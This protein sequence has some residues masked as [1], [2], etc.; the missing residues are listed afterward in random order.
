MRNILQAA[1]KKDISGY[2]AST[3]RV[4][5]A[6]KKL[7]KH[8]KEKLQEQVDAPR[9]SAK[10]VS[11]YT[12]L[13]D[14]ACFDS[15]CDDLCTTPPEIGR[16]RRHPNLYLTNFT[17]KR[18]NKEPQPTASECT[19][20]FA[21]ALHMPLGWNRVATE[22]NALTILSGSNPELAMQLFPKVESPLPIGGRGCPEDVRAYAAI[23][24]FENYWNAVGIKGLNNI[25]NMSRHIGD[26]GEYPYRAMSSVMSKLIDLPSDD[27]RVLASEILNEAIRYYQRGSQFLNRDEEFFAL[28][29]RVRDFAS[30]NDYLPGLRLLVRN[31]L[32]DRVSNGHFIAEIGTSEGFMRFTDMNLA[33]LFR[34]FPLLAEADSHWAELLMDQYPELRKA[35]VKI[36]YVAAGIVYGDAAPLELAR[37]QKELLQQSLVNN[38]ARVQKENSPEILQM[39]KRLTALKSAPLDELLMPTGQLQK[40]WHESGIRPTADFKMIKTKNYG[41]N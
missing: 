8:G 12:D 5:D 13:L 14:G 4:K 3:D 11:A 32:A 27:R 29:E 41:K 15:V 24:I 26:T 17:A 20:L 2:V 10:C 37:L 31:L 7:S 38:I 33:L 16:F 18:F 39:R 9:Y 36:V 28:L 25:R 21:F 34:V 40:P 22:K 19:R 23:E 1:K 6:V 30:A 35:R